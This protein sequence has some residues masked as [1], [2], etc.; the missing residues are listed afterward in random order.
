MLSTI[1]K[2]VNVYVDKLSE[3]LKMCK[4]GCSMNGPLINHIMYVDDL[5]LISPS[6]S[7]L[8]QLLHKCEEFG[9]NYD[10]KHHATKSAVMI[11]RSV[12][13]K[14]YSFRGFKLNGTHLPFIKNI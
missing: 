10:V 14:G 12:T 2:V 5:V 3:Q 11:F 8:W 4:V 7:G 1:F 9:I 6:T 13:L